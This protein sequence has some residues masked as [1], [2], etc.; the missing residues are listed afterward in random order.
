MEKKKMKKRK[1]KKKRTGTN[2]RRKTDREKERGKD[3]GDACTRVRAQ[4]LISSCLLARLAA[5]MASP[6]TVAEKHA[7]DGKS[8]GS[9]I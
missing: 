4:N 1:K 3:D 6:S 2:E 5:P 8:R 7:R 9:P